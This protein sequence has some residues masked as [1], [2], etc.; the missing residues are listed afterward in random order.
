[1][2]GV[3]GKFPDYSVTA[4]VSLEKGKEFKTITN[5]DYA[6]KWKIY[7]FWTKD[8]RVAHA[9]SRPEGP[10]HSRCSPTSNAN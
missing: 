8:S 5:D 3:G 10:A 4:T 6:G 7:F 9:S 1:M 2:L